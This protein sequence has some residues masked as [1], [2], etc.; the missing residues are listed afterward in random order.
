MYIAKHI[1]WLEGERSAI[2]E[3]GEVVLI[4]IFN[5][6]VLIIKIYILHQYPKNKIKKKTPPF[7]HFY[8]LN[9]FTQ[10]IQHVL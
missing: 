4:V 3:Q 6:T 1:T 10:G 7:Y 8:S 9:L 2:L 5:I